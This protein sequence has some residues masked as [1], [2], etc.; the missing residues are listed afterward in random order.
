[1]GMIDQI[2]AANAGR[3][4]YN[5][6]C[7]VCKVRL[8]QEFAADYRRQQATGEIASTPQQVVERTKKVLCS[9]CLRVYNEAMGNR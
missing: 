6:L 2:K 4:M 5:K 1:M 7:N 3:R 9:R 8:T